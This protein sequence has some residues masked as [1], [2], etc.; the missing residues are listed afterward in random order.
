MTDMLDR[1]VPEAYP[2]VRGKVRLSAAEGEL[3]LDCR[4]FR[5]G[6]VVLALIDRYLERF[7]GADRR[8]ALSLWTLYY[9][10][11]LVIS[12]LLF[13]LRERRI[14]AMAMGDTRLC[15]DGLTGAPAAFLVATEGEIRTDSTVFDAMRNAIR[16]HAE[17]VIEAMAAT[18]KVSPKLLWN[19]LAVYADW[20][21]REF[22]ASDEVLRHAA[23]ELITCQAW[24]DGW[25]NPMAGQLRRETDSDGACFTRRK[26]CCL[27]YL[28]P[29]VPGCGMIC[30][31][32]AGR[33]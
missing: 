20:A 18:G 22:G 6:A 14:M 29:G 33:E 23:H 16:D 9:F 24:P 5:D 2:Y 11:H 17:P 8:A 32:P 1:L 28:V 12:P 25:K 3:V 15:I 27:R 13:W 10:S 4:D 26:I 31:L 21:I 30:P 7:P 19:N